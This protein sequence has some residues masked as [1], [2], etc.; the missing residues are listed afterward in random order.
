MP[1]RRKH[2]LGPPSLGRYNSRKPQRAESVSPET[3]NLLK[4]NS[5]LPLKYLLHAGQMPK[6]ACKAM[7]GGDSDRTQSRVIKDLSTLGILKS[8]SLHATYKLAFPIKL[9]RYLFPELWVEAE[10]G[11]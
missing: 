3:P 7:L 6:Q 11:Q 4:L 10:S 2:L 5:L 1:H 8:E 9:F